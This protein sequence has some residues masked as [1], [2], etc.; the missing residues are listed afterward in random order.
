MQAGS[1]QSRLSMF[2]SGVK[3]L[4]PILLGVFPFGLVVGVTAGEAG[5][6]VWQIA[7]QSATMF[8]GTAQITF[9]HL[10]ELGSPAWVAVVSTVI[11]NVRLL[12]YGF[13]IA[14]YWQELPKGW[15]L[16]M[17]FF[18]TDQ[19]YA[20]SLKEY[21]QETFSVAKKI[22]C[23]FGFSLIFYMLWI[24]STMLGNLL[25]V[26]IPLSWEI[27]FALPLVFLTLLIAILRKRSQIISAMVAGL[28]ALLLHDLPHNLGF[29][30][31]VFLGIV[32]GVLLDVKNGDVQADKEGRT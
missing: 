16:A 12:L 24:I 22:W 6:D 10:R 8:S 30:M 3:S 28:C 11:V 20:I 29:L 1:S 14:P 5:Y 7:L 26:F 27:N 4:P 17:G 15:R 19:A 32:V 21:R 23:F 9:I 13:S 31:A 2:M 18:L 25:G